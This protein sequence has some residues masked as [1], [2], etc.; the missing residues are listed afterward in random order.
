MN[1]IFVILFL[2]AITTFP[3]SQKNIF[4]LKEEMKKTII[5][6]N[7]NSIPVKEEFSKKS[8]ILAITYS[9]LLP[10]MGELYS[11]NYNTGKYFTIAEGVFWGTYIGIN[12]Y[13]NWQKDRYHSFAASNG[14]VNLA[15]KSDDYFANIGIYTD[16]NEYNDYMSRGGEFD[17]MYDPQA[18]YWK[19]TGNDRKAYRDMWSA[20]EQSHNSLRFVIGALVLNRVASAIDA[21]RLAAAYNKNASQELGWNIS[22]GMSNVAT[23][24]TGVVVNFQL[25]L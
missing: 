25:G 14:G 12:Q 19:W 20:G 10:G 13:S 7:S 18:N 3:Q 15:G 11:G 17:K 4:S 23:L 8:V 24:P 5:A 22:A 9:L 2:L 6:G 1:K 16:V 21:A